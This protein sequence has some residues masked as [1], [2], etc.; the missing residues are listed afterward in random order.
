M[1]ER[2]FGCEDAVLE[3]KKD[4]R[5]HAV[6]Q[7]L[8]D[9]TGVHFDCLNRNYSCVKFHLNFDISIRLKAY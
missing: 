2:L 5:M 9:L 3:S 1:E 6:I 7:E 4:I 8:L